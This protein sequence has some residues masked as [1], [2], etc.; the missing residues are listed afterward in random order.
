ME[1]YPLNHYVILDG[2]AA[3]DI[4]RDLH[5]WL[6]ELNAQALTDRVW[7]YS[8]VAGSDESMRRLRE[9]NERLGGLSPRADWQPFRILFLGPNGNGSFSY[10]MSAASVSGDGSIG[11]IASGS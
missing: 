1:Q 6:G 9:I 8:S 4:L 5:R 11:A 7:V 3:D 10:R 2:A